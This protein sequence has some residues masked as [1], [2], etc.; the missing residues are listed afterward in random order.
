MTF[1]RPLAA[2]LL[3]ACAISTVAVTSAVAAPP[4]PAQMVLQRQ[5]LPAGFALTGRR[6]RPNAAVAAETGVRL[7]LLRSWGRTG[8]HEATYDREVDPQ[9]PPPGPASVIAVVSTYRSTAGLRSAFTASAARIDRDGKPKHRPTKLGARLGD[10]ARLWETRFEQDGV[11]VVLYTIVWRSRGALGYLSVA[12]V[13]GRL[14][15]ADAL[16]LA[17]R[18][19][20][21]IV[22]T[23]AGET[24]GLVA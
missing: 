24:P 17:R 16:A 23:T 13:R 8:G 20:A 15:P 1:V 3:A 21:R 14:K 2:A 4:D 18:Q 6:D 19:H 22:A 11:S 7:A 10:A 5:D 12:G 9:A